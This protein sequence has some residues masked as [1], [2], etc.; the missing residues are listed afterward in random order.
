MVHTWFSHFYTF[1]HMN[2]T[3]HPDKPLAVPG[4]I[5]RL[6]NTRQHLPTKILKKS[7]DSLLQQNRQVRLNECIREKRVVT[8]GQ[9]SVALFHTI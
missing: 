3:S 6:K 9:P 5:R 4:A 2:L 7:R 1:L 8:K